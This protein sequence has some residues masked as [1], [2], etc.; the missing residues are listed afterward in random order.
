MKRK[1]MNGLFQI[2]V[3]LG[4]FMLF[5]FYSNP[6]TGMPEN[7]NQLWLMASAFMVGGGVIGYFTTR[8]RRDV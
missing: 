3:F 8:R 5:L 1:T 7:T 4:A 2:M 6:T